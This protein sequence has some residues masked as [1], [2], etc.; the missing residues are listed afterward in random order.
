MKKKAGTFFKNVFSKG[1]N[2]FKKDQNEENE[3]D[4]EFDTE[5]DRDIIEV[6]K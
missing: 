4:D 2:L 6:G 1:K 5:E 3:K